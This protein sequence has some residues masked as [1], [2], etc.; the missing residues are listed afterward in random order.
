MNPSI[1]QP[2]FGIWAKITNVQ[3][4]FDWVPGGEGVDPSEN[5]SIVDVLQTIIDAS[6]DNNDLA[7]ALRKLVK[8]FKRAASQSVVTAHPNANGS[9]REPLVIRSSGSRAEIVGTQSFNTDGDRINMSDSKGL[10]DA[11]KR[12]LKKAELESIRKSHDSPTPE[13]LEM[14]NPGILNFSR[15]NMENI[16]RMHAESMIADE[17]TFEANLQAINEREARKMRLSKGFGNLDDLRAKINAM[18]S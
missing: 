18:N 8:S 16:D 2:N 5:A 1:L 13:E 10:L 14:K 6:N 4:A 15:V 9:T 7:A 12:D 11:C 3:S 17:P